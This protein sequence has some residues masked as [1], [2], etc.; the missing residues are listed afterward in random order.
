MT[1]DDSSSTPGLSDSL[2]P[3]ATEDGHA[4]RATMNVREAGQ[5]NARISLLRRRAFRLE[6]ITIAWNIVEGGAA[7]MWNVRRV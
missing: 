7:Y 3:L 6:Y 5:F 4:G 1:L 2:D